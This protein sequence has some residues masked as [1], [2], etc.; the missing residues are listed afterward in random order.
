MTTCTSCV[1]GCTPA[2][3]NSAGV[4]IQVHTP[5]GWTGVS[6]P[7]PTYCAARAALATYPT[8]DGIE[9]RVYSAL[10]PAVKE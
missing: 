2:E 5:A 7:Y 6:E 8:N 10:I 3:K 1:S 9:R 4:E